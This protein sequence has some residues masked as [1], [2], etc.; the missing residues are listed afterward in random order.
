M[1]ILHAELVVEAE[2]ITLLVSMQL[3]VKN[4]IL[5]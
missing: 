2:H 4:V 3:K 1:S 5:K